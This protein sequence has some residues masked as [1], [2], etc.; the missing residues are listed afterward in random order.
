MKRV[1][2]TLVMLVSLRIAHAEDEW[3]KNVPADTQKKAQALFGEANNLFAEE[4]HAPALEKYKAALALWDHPLIH[5]NTAVTEIRLDRILDA[6]DDLD[7]AL[8]FGAKPFPTKELYQQALDY[9]NL[10]K[11]RVGD[12]SASCD[13]AHVHVNLDGK[14][15]LTCPG[16]ATA[17]V[18]VGEHTLIGTDDG[19]LYVP[20]TRRIVVGGGKA[21]VERLRLRSV[22][23]DFV[24]KYPYPRWIPFTIAGGGAAVALGGLAFW[25]AGKS[26]MD[27]FEASFASQCQT[28]CPASLDGS[29]G[30]RLLAEE[31][32]SAK[33]KGKIAVSMMIAGGAITVTGVVFIVLNKAKRVL[34][35]EVVPNGQ[36]GAS[37]IYSGSF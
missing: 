16:N 4:K 34:P 14:P 28:G 35:V 33:L 10:V 36:G 27:H 31:R 17:R 18:L 8:A 11:G 3:A 1:L 30:Q 20:E 37:A 5:F 26:Q 29:E 15:W 32:D 13:Q 23:S 2:V 9:Q 12:I 24:L 25:F 21:N 7:K 22:D 19:K 6:A